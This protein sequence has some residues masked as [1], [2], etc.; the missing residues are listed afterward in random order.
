MHRYA[1]RIAR[2]LEMPMAEAFKLPF[3]FVDFLTK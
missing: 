3:E 1:S 2:L